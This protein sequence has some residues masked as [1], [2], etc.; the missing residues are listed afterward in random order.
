MQIPFFSGK[1]GGPTARGSR[2]V[3]LDHAAASPV[4]PRV[5]EAMS[6]YWSG[7][8]ANA[9][10]IHR[11]GLDARDALMKARAQVAD[12]VRARTSDVVFTSGGTESNN[13][14]LV[15]VV[16]ALVASGTPMHDIEIISTAIEHPSILETLSVLASRGA[17]V[18]YV[19][20]TSEGL[21]DQKVFESLLSPKTKLV[22]FAYVNSEIGVVQEVKKLSRANTT[23]CIRTYTSMLHRLRCGFLYTS[24]A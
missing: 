6:P 9:R 19:P 12:V 11:D 8:F 15:G 13:L 3:Y 21:V 2:R 23:V 20:V 16:E 4:D 17:V 5:L 10:S 22:T 7:V 18:K 14:A 24:T 1:K